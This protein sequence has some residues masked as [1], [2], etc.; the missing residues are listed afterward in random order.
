MNEEFWKNAPKIFADNAN[1][2]VTRGVGNTFLLAL[3]SGKNA[4]VFVFTPEHMKRFTQLVV[5]NVNEY[6]KVD[7]EI[8]VEEWTPDMKSPF[9]IEDSQDSKNKES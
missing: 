4:N 9:S 3:R 8:E 5:H 7:G 1:I 2:A 6:E